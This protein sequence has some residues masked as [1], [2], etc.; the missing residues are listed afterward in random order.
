MT[1]RNFY[2]NIWT[3]EEEREEI[4]NMLKYLADNEFVSV[5]VSYLKRV[6]LR[7]KTLEQQ[8][9]TYEEDAL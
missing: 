4:E 2:N 9:K 7:I 3:T 6:A 1:D 5:S 8:V